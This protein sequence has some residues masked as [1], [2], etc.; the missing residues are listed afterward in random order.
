MNV[1]VDTSTDPKIITL[2]NVTYI[3]KFLTNI[4]SMS[5]FEI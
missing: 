1:D 5:L 3:Q 2:Q 4:T